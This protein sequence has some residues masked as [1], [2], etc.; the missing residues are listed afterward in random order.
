LVE[1]S[2][3][4][5]DK[6]LLGEA[7]LNLGLLYREKKKT[8]QARERLSEAVRIFEECEIDVFLR[9]AKEALEQ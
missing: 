1:V 6:G 8:D 4:I 7:Y 2:K 9:E 3:E 5:G